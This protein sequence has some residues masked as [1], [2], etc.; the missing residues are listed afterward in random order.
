MLIVFGGLPGVGKSE[1]ARRVAGELRAAY[2]RV[3]AIESALV[4]A[5]LVANQQSVGPA[6]YQVAEEIA[7]SNLSAGIAVVVDAVNPVA[8]CR[9][10][11]RRVSQATGARLEFVEV[12]CSDEA[13]HRRRVQSRTSDLADLV[14]PTWEQVQQR[15]YEPWDDPVLVVD[16]VDVGAA[17]RLI[18]TALAAPIGGFGPKVPN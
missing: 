3:D 9:D 8:V 18:L 12:I 2:V 13:E 7:H 17:V 16:N 4:T 1:L 10:G 15:E 14:A 6:G 5:G 11:W